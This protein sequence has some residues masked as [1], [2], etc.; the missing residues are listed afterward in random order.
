MGFFDPRQPV[1]TLPGRLLMIVAT[2]GISSAGGTFFSLDT[3]ISHVPLP[4]LPKLPKAPER[5]REQPGGRPGDRGR[6]RERLSPPAELNLSS[7]ESLQ[8]AAEPRFSWQAPGSPMKMRVKSLH[9]ARRAEII[10]SADLA[11]FSA[12]AYA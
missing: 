1:S 6:A 5:L 12:D 9:M 10:C 8:S 11:S 3:P 2:M 7:P 4:K